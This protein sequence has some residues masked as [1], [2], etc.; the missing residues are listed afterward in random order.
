VT[1]ETIR[2]IWEGAEEK[3]RNHFTLRYFKFLAQYFT[4]DKIR[5]TRRVE[6]V[7]RMGEKRNA[8]RM[9]VGR[10]EGDRLLGRSRRRWKSNG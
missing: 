8:Y 3:N 6:H 9:F 4:D 1:A 7:I 10:T 5:E 2:R